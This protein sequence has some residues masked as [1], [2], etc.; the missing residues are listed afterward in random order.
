MANKK[1]NV[2]GVSNVAK[3]LA[4]GVVAGAKVAAGAT[5][6][7]TLRNG[8][9]GS[10]VEK[11]QKALVSA[12]YDVGKA[13]A[14][15]VYGSATA[16][17][18]KQYQKDHG[19]AVDGIAGKN[20][21]GALYNSGNAGLSLMANNAVKAAQMTAGNDAG[22]KAATVNSALQ[23]LAKSGVQAGV[24]AAGG[25]PDYPSAVKGTKSAPVTKSE[26][27][28]KEVV[29]KQPEKTSTPTGETAAPTTADGFT[30]HDFVASD[31]VNQ[32][33]AILGQHQSSQPGAYNPVWQD[34]ADAYLNQYQNRDPFSY[35]FANDAL[36]QQY[37]DMYIQ[38]GQMASMDAMGQAAAMT[39][40]YG[41]SYSQSAGQQAYNQ[42]LTQL[43]AVVP[44]LAQ[45]AQDRYNLEGQ[46]MLDMY[47]LYMDRENQEYA[48]YQDTYDRWYQEMAR[49]Q[50]N[51][52]TLYDRE[53]NEYWAGRQEAYDDYW[54]ELDR[55]Y[56]IGRD[57]VEDEHWDKEYELQKKA[58]RG[59]PSSP[60]TDEDRDHGGDTDPTTGLTES[61]QM[62]IENWIATACANANGPSFD[63]NKLIAGTSYLTSEAEREYAKAVVAAMASMR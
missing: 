6:Q 15:G 36:Y 42:Y 47:S 32:A 30:Y 22:K 4:Q 53:Y 19:L 63:P 12:G 3:T 14:D 50:S 27:V 46:R 5:T 2:S 8:S 24:T 55:E 52:D 61:R 60:T 18:V 29:D 44:E 51:Y 54:R 45:M 57:A 49:L 10:D 25:T 13:G 62:E 59:S 33:Y 38:Q 17:A 56:Q 20:T 37:K 1:E 28:A 9:T 35:N 11:L 7:P 40:G 58:S 31:L 23:T 48:K 21:L 34:E 26:P 43:N 16:A 39:G 41:N